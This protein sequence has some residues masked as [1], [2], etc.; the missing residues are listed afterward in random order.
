MHFE[1]CDFIILC[2]FVAAMLQ[3]EF[4]K[5]RH[6]YHH[7]LMCLYYRNDVAVVIVRERWCVMSQLENGVIHKIDGKL[8]NP[9]QN[10]ATQI[11]I[12]VQMNDI[13]H[14]NGDPNVQFDNEAVP[15]NI[16]L[17]KTPF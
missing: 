5:M 6:Q 13:N 3:T 1:A 2:E 14:M 9:I 11:T 4:E 17:K 16:A 10:G 8:T 12:H 15:S 7:H